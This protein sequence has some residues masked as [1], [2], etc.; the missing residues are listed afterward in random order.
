MSNKPSQLPEATDASLESFVRRARVE[1]EQAAPT[2]NYPILEPDVRARFFMRFG[3][4]LC[5]LASLIFAIISQIF[6]ILMLP[7]VPLYRSFVDPLLVVLQVVIVGTLFCLLSVSSIKV[8][9]RVAAAIG[10]LI[11]ILIFGKFY[12]DYGTLLGGIMQ[13]IGFLYKFLLP[14]L[15][16]LFIPVPFILLIRWVAETQ[17]SSYYRPFYVPQRLIPALILFAVFAMMGSMF[18]FSAL[19]RQAVRAMDAMMKAATSA[20]TEEALPDAVRNISGTPF[21]P[22]AEGP[23]YLSAAHN[24]IPKRVYEDGT[25]FVMDITVTAAFSSGYRLSCD[26]ARATAKVPTCRSDYLPPY[27]S[28]NN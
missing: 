28:V 25:P 21:L 9:N 27:P 1:R 24:P 19:E 4:R 26:F 8:Q 14:I 23:Y 18:V 16:V 3:V 20:K 22:H 7:A 6:N 13:G 11:L 5:F 2:L 12:M 17:V 10:L 15:F